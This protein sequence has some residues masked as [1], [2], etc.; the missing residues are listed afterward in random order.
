M[1]PGQK[2]KHPQIEDRRWAIWTDAHGRKWGAN[3]SK[4]TGRPA[5]PLKPQGWSAPVKGGETP[6]RYL[7]YS[8]NPETP[9]AI[10]IDYEGLINAYRASLEEWQAEVQRQGMKYPDKTRE[11]LETIVGPKPFPWQYWLACKDS[12]A[13]GH[14]WALGLS[15][16]RPLWADDWFPKTQTVEASAGFLYP[17]KPQTVGA[18]GRNG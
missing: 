12:I 9:R 14:R 7:R 13:E 17:R 6:Q 11:Q 18:G 10:A 8:D 15:E 16:Q 5:E 3:E 1:L 2:E 4:R